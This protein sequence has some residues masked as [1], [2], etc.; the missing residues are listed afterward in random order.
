M[1]REAQEMTKK[2]TYL[3]PREQVFIREYLKD[4][5]ATRSAIAAG[6]SAHTAS[7]KGSKLLRKAKVS[8][9]L[10]KLREKLL[11]KLEITA[12]RVIEGL[13]ELAFFD[14]RRMFNEDGSLKRIVDMDAVTVRAITGMDVE[15]LFRHFGK[16]QAE[17]MGTITKIRMAD[18]GV[19]LERLGRYFKLFTDRVEVSDTTEI[20]N[21]L[22]AGRERA[23]VLVQ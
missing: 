5:N 14:P 4:G 9:E 18:R 1:L 23:A 19:N 6:Y 16:G 15:K 22:K 20:L 2:F 21:R 7:V 11:N 12:E 8:A 13:G 17:E 10:G 3:S